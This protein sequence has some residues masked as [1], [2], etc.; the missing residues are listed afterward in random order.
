MTIAKVATRK[1]LKQLVRDVCKIERVK[2]IIFRKEIDRLEK[3]DGIYVGVTQTITVCDYKKSM[4]YILLT[5]FHELGHHVAVRNNLWKRYHCG[6]DVTF[7]AEYAFLIENAIDRI[8]RLLWKK[9]VDTKVWGR[10][11]FTYTKAAKAHFVKF[12][13]GYYN[14]R[15]IS[16]DVVETIKNLK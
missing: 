3:I 12:L 9:Y 10:Y 7:T 14:T 2:K 4:R 13:T 8:A 6:H 15:P 11:K 5:A 16:K 1:Q